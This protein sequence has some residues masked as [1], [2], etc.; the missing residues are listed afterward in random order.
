MILW[1][2]D[3]PSGTTHRALLNG[4]DSAL[5]ESLRCTLLPLLTPQLIA[6][7]EKVC[8]NTFS[9]IGEI[10]GGSLCNCTGMQHCFPWDV[11]WDGKKEK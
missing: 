9:C 7:T 11:H 8:T 3:P 4:M 1:P 6:R 2:T 5:T 10:D